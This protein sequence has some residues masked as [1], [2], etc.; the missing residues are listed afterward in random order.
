MLSVEPENRGF[1]PFMTKYEAQR[2]G[3]RDKAGEEISRVLVVS[4]SGFF[5]WSLEQRTYGDQTL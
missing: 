5:C 2:Y 1:Q 3:K 4:N